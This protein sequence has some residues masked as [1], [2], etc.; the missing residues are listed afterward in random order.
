MSKKR[1]HE[2]AKELKSHGIELDNKEVVTELVALGYDVKSH[3]SSLEDDQ[4]SSAVQA[5]LNKRKP[6]APEPPV[7][8]KGFVVRRKAAPVETQAAAAALPPAAEPEPEAPQAEPAEVAA[9]A[10][11]APVEAAE[12]APVAP[13]TEAAAP[14]PV[15]T[16][17]VPA[18]ATAPETP[19]AATAA[20]VP[21]S[22]PAATPA[23]VAQPEPPAARPAQPTEARPAAAAVTPPQVRT[24]QPT[25]PTIRPGQPQHRPGA[26]VTHRPGG[27]V[28]HRPTA[29]V[30]QRPGMAAAS[31]AA[32]QQAQATGPT[33]PPKPTEMRRTAF[34][35]TAVVADRATARPTATQA[36][37]VSRPLVQVRR[38]TPSTQAHRNI[39]VAPGRK[40][41][42]EVREFKVVTDHT[43]RGGKEFVDVSKN[44]GAKKRTQDNKETG[45]REQMQDVIW[46]R[47]ALPIRGKKRKP[48]KK[49]QKTQITQMA[50]E[51]K[52]IKLQ[53]GISVSELGQ[54]MG[55]RTAELIKKLMGLGKMATANQ[56]IDAD[57]AELL[58][59]D[60]GWKIERTG[61]EV[62]DYLPEVEESPENN[63]P[64]PPVIT[65][66]GHVDHG[67]TSLLDAIRSAD[68]AS[69]EAGGITQ[70]IGAYTVHTDKGD[71]TFLDTPGHEA[72][73]SMRARG[74]NVTDLVILVVAAD[75]GV[76]PT[77]REAVEHARAAEVPIVV[78]INKMDLAAANPDRVKKEL[79][80]L[81][82]LPE[83]WGGDTI[84]VPVSARTKDGL[85]NLLDSVL[86]QAEVLELQANP[87]K[88]AVGTIIEA[89]LDKGRG[90]VATVL[91]QEGTLKKGD[92]VVTGTHYGRVR[93]LIN[94]RGEQVDEVLPGY[95]AE[96]LGLS[97]VPTAGDNLNA[98]ADEKAAKE[99]AE[100]RN[101]KARQADIGKTSKETRTA[102]SRASAR[103]TG[104]GG[105]RGARP[106]WAASVVVARLMARAP[107][108]PRGGEHAPAHNEG[109]GTKQ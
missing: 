84:M 41:I 76:M 77:T 99:I 107:L 79:A 44:K 3:S 28:T 47:V 6:K 92:P 85:N 72:F 36:V 62:E 8:A 65:V 56:I 55:V 31:G 105:G 88:P 89:K 30:T 40:A 108:A 96:V 52:V 34:G 66:M 100:H 46:G 37:V 43:G 93:I 4:A 15:E 22:E 91:V 106:T 35:Q 16:A 50:E 82:L 27:P 94:D 90:P 23:A 71:L 103:P 68:V 13:A 11:P 49:G 109:S 69:G 63:R 87:N 20:P 19:A 64:R 7:T 61:F 42:G 5:I 59:T 14:A 26:P 45:I 9:A 95:S 12:P 80:D 10:E 32:G 29:P 57:T 1:V 33:V 53:E 51:K 74:A 102:W 58:A 2:I 75:D 25:P 21:P 70:H 78:A 54:T 86:L 18:A 38:V 73:T 48:T 17:P 83:D 39:P 97:G 60:Y 81:N 24:G 101:L 98:V 104:P 67:K